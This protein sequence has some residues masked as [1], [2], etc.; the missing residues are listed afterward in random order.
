MNKNL[1]KSDKLHLKDEKLESISGGCIYVRPHLC[2]T[3]KGKRKIYEVINDKTG[4]EMYTFCL[5]EY[6]D[7]EN[8][9]KAIEYAKEHDMRTDFIKGDGLYFL[10]AKHELDELYGK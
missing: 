3:K 8:R 7:E 1:N 9:A 2:F 10:K 4:E 6:S 5:G